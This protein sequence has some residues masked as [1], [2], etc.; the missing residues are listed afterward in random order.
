MI[1][2][3]QGDPEST[4]YYKILGKYIGFLNLTLKK[5]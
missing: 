4:L 1:L 5:H 2:N 3:I